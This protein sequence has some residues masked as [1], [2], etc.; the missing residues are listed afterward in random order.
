MGV[1]GRKEGHCV[2]GY[3]SNVLDARLRD[4]TLIF[5]I[6]KNGKVLSTLELSVGL[7]SRRYKA[8]ENDEN[9]PDIFREV[10]SASIVQNRAKRNGT[11]CQEAQDIAEKLR[12]HI[13]TL[14]PELFKAYV[15]DMQSSR[16]IQR[17]VNK[18]PDYI[19][20]TGY[21]PF[22]KEHLQDAWDELSELLPRSVRKKGLD[23]FIESMDV[24]GVK[25]SMQICIENENPWDKDILEEYRV[26]KLEMQ[27][28]TDPEIEVK[29][30]FAAAFATGNPEDEDDADLE[31][32]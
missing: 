29:D 9:A 12:K 4:A 1:Q 8:D 22:N 3:V 25:L 14:D 13:E 32:A 10:L 26:Q 20:Q 31:L 2:G 11:P 16:E 30:V 7:D 17:K 28:R 27:K 18:L 5:S 15:S 6:E 19:R 21:S 24:T 23:A